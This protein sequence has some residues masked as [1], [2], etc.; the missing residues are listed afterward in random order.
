MTGFIDQLCLR[1][2]QGTLE[3]NL[4]EGR[5]GTLMR[6]S[7]VQAAPL[8]VAATIREVTGRGSENLTLLGLASAVK[9]EWIEEAFPEQVTAKIEHLYDRTHKRVA[10]VRLVRFRDLVIHHEHQRE[11][12]PKAS[13]QCLA[14]AYRTG[15]FELP[16]FNHELKQL[17]S[18]VNLV[19]A[20][21]PELEFPPF[22][23]AAITA[24]LARAFEGLTLAKEAQ[25]THLREVFVQA[26][27]KEQLGW[28]DELAPTSIPWPDGRKVKLLYPEQ[29]HD[30]DGQPNS[31]ELQVKLHECFVLKAHPHICEGRLP[32]KL[33]L[34]A[35]EGKRLEATTNWTAFRV[36]SYPKLKPALQKKHPGMP[37]P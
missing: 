30:E 31:P 10:A 3:C 36:N 22:N 16:L 7:V 37:W 5:Q 29:A 9:R 34:C 27:A 11:V 18:R 15:Y 28:L 14:E 20:V 26:L 23:E 19:V 2:D 1:H 13:G 4:T 12:D 35:P 6:E 8:F 33:W 25:A 24:C 17:I 32:V 21:M